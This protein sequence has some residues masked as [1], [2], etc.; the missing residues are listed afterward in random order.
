MLC[1]NPAARLAFLPV[2][3]AT[4]NPTHAYQNILRNFLALYNNLLLNFFIILKK[5]NFDKNV[6]DLKK[7]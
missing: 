2:P 7:I 3:Q 4:L 6:F 5:K 1:L